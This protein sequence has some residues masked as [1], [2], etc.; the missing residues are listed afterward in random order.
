MHVSGSGD[1]KGVISALKNIVKTEGW[2]GL[3]NGIGPKLAQSVIT[4]AFLFAFKDA[5]FLMAVQARNNAQKLKL[6]AR[7]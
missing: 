3:Y 6:A 1:K 5:I 7:K 2:Q 4:A